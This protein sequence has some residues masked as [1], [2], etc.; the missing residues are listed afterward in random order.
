MHSAI[1]NLLAA[2]WSSSS[3]IFFRVAGF[4][5]GCGFGVGWGFGE[6]RPD[7]LL[8]TGGPPKEWFRHATM[9]HEGKILD[10]VK[11]GSSLQTLGIGAGDTQSLA[12]FRE[13]GGCGVGL[14]LGWGFG[15][16]YG[17]RYVD[18]KPKFEGINFDDLKGKSGKDAPPDIPAIVQ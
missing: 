13:G 17:T 14:G 10:I 12:Q 4:G 3:W 16:A 18:S 1:A 9:P 2:S 5:A 15:L 11:L 7:S 6:V 8:N